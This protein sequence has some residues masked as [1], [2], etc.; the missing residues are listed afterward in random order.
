MTFRPLVPFAPSAPK[1]EVN[2][3]E[4]IRDCCRTNV[5][6]PSGMVYGRVQPVVP[7]RHGEPSQ[8]ASQHRINRRGSQGYLARG[9]ICRETLTPMMSGVYPLFEEPA[10]PLD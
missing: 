6:P 5:P 3:V 9:M 4:N 7:R 1:C 8:T 10:L 2:L